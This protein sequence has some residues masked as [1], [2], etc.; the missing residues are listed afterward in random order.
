MFETNK[1][2]TF[3]KKTFELL[4]NLKKWIKNNFIDSWKDGEEE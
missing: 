3:Y 4:Y 2:N 1:I